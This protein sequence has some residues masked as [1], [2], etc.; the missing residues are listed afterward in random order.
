MTAKI[1]TTRSHI[2]NWVILFVHVRT[3]A[4]YWGGGVDQEGIL[5]PPLAQYNI[6]DAPL[7]NHT[8]KVLTRLLLETRDK[9]VKYQRQNS[10]KDFIKQYIFK[11]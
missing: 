6:S 10:D 1:A 8:P 9:S 11:R 2:T 7:F 5:S 3:N 4:I